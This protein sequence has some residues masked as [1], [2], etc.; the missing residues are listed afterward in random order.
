MV[1]IL[2]SLMPFQRAEGSPPRRWASE[3]GTGYEPEGTMDREVT[4]GKKARSESRRTGRSDSQ[5]SPASG[6]VNKE[7]S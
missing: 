2:L 1:W 5:V 3:T 7:E 4:A 6:T